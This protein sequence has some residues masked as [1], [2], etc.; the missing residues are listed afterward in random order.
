MSLHNICYALGLGALLQWAAPGPLWAQSSLRI[1][2]HWP[3]PQAMVSAE[4]LE[5]TVTF[6]NPVAKESVTSR[7]FHVF[8][9]WSG[10]CP[11][12]LSFEDNDRSIL[13][14][15]TRQPSA[16]EWVTVAL[17]RG[18][19]DQAGGHLSRGFAWN[20]WTRAEPG[21]L[22]LEKE[23]TISV[24][25][26]GEAG[27]RTYGA[28]AG[29]L[30]GDGYHD[31]T[32]PN[33]DSHDI[34]V[35]MN[36]GSGRY[37]PFSV[38]ALPPGSKPSTNE[39]GD[40]DGDGL[41]DFACGNIDGNSVSVFR[42]DGR[43]SLSPPVTYSVGA[44]TRGLAVLDLNGDGAPDI[45]TAN[46]AAS[47]ISKLLNNGDGTFGPALSQALAMERETS[48]SAAD[49]NEDGLM[50]LVVG[51]YNAGI[52]GPGAVGEIAVLAS[53]GMGGLGL[54]SKIT[55]KGDAWMLAVGDVNNDGHVDV[56]SANAIQNELAVFFGD[57]SGRLSQGHTY[58]V[59]RFPLAI[60]L[61]DIDGD[62]DLDVVTSNFQSADWTLYENDGTGVFI[63]PRTL[64]TT[65]AGSCAVLHD[66]DR[67]G[68]LDMTGIDE[69]ADNLILFENPARPTGIKPPRVPDNFQLHQSFPN[70]FEISAARP[71]TIPFTLRQAARITIDVVNLRGQ[72]VVTIT[73]SDFAAGEHRESF[74]PSNLPAGIYF[75]R[76]FS[77]EAVVVR[78][79]VI[80]P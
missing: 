73:E 59:G 35:F 24:R 37:G 67:D 74:L 30:D 75:Y 34:R 79:A 8:G 19:T 57:G 5:I 26:P 68:D 63:N 13:F 31:F 18:I 20:F 61:G 32:V 45:V 72:R 66:R 47:N 52:T 70:P 41:L 60:D 42:G 15:L 62:G 71:L 80:I 48:C 69:L 56:V 39:G 44:G 53:D 6:D 50:D 77:N 14:S 2:T 3:P 33:E 12:V 49:F 25:R 51:S 64:R 7:T 23:A 16:G 28:Y 36:N 11:G 58:P 17:A 76:L 1:E 54:F 4:N 9:R 65:R 21:M 38:H 10:V 43:G 55:A 78:K 22:D 46:R 40:F 29:D 27:I